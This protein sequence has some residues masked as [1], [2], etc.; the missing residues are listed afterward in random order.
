VVTR[1]DYARAERFL[2]CNL[3]KLVY[4]AEVQPR[5][6]GRSDRFWYRVRAREGIQFVLVDPEA[7]TRQPAFDH[8]LLA[9]A[10]STATG[11]PIE[12]TRLPFQEIEVVDGGQAIRFSVD[13]QRWHYDVAGNALRQFEGPPAA[14]PNEVA[15]PDGCWAAFVRDGKLWVRSLDSGGE[16]QLTS[17]GTP[18]SPYALNADDLS[19]SVT[20]ALSREP[21]K[22]SLVWSPGSRRIAT[23]KLRMDGVQELWLVQSVSLDGGKR[24]RL[25]RF[26]APMP[27]DEQV[28]LASL[29]LIDLASGETA[30]V[31]TEP[32]PAESGTPLDTGLVW[33]SNDGE[34]VY[35]V[36]ERRG[37]RQ[38]DLH[39]VAATGGS[40]QP[41]LTETSETYVDFSAD[42]YPPAARSL[43]SG[44]VVWWSERDGWGHLYLFDGETGQLV[45]QLTSGAWQ[46]RMVQHVDEGE[47]LVYFT[48]GGRESGRDP[49]FDHLYRVSLDGGEPELLTPEDAHHQITAAPSGRFFIDSY[50]RVDLPPVTVLRDERGRSLQTLETADVDALLATGFRYPER[51]MVKAEDGL[52]DL[53]GILVLP[54]GFDHERR[55]PVLDDI[56][57]GPQNYNTP[58]S[59]NFMTE[60]WQQQHALAELGFAVVVLDGRGTAHRS[61]A[62][63]D[64]AYG[65]KFGEAGGLRDHVAGLRQLAGQRPYLDLDRLGIFGHSGGGFASARA[66]LVYPE[67]FKVA[68]SCAGNHNQ[69][70]YRTR[71]GERYLG[72]YD[73]E[74]Y[75]A[76]DNARLADRL[77][78][79]LFLVHGELDDDV[80]PSMTLALVDA[81]IKADKDFDLLILPNR[82][83]DFSADTYFIRRRWDYFVQH[84]LGVPPP[85]NYR[86]ESKPEAEHE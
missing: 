86:I 70:W 63:H 48:A 5:F 11:T 60:Y 3:A 29:A 72:L 35:F 49:Y 17:D 28:P 68:V 62:F 46:V 81:L 13:E 32:L 8:V 61:K 36:R 14:G 26:P 45:R 37:H 50:S 76:G 33:W 47:R 15:S 40:V 6:I 55:Y 75:A 19:T 59:F 4:R 44:E 74:V 30:L 16:R 23:V 80:P 24:P 66:M 38:A 69:A 34:R 67:F 9:A 22:P 84:L 25:H 65:E 51:F 83:H 56:Y 42:R 57:P 1:E 64:F 79:K 77:E 10:L 78:G 82:D 54:S 58:K 31:E 21:S 12:H 73:P 85:R 39:V 43:G 2:P 18:E 71:W 20:E 7:N 52:T 53:Y 27:M 41:V